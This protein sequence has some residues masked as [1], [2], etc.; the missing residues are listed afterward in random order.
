LVGLEEGICASKREDARKML[1]RGY[2]W[3]AI[4]DITGIRPEDLT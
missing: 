2:E 1:A 3:N 4:T